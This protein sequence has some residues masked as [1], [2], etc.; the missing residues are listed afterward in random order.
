MVFSQP[1]G[2]QYTHAVSRSLETFEGKSFLRE[3]WGVV[4][5]GAW[6]SLVRQKQL[7]TK[8]RVHIRF[9]HRLRPA[10]HRLRN[11]KVVLEAMESWAGPE[12]L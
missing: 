3:I 7:L 9:V 5:F 2:K 12:Y 6:C 4:K 8:V 11:E 10:L 1:K